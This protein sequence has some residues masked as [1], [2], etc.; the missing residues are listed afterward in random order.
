MEWTRTYEISTWVRW[1]LPIALVVAYLW[2]L[3]ALFGALFDPTAVSERRWGEALQPQ[4]LVFI[5]VGLG[6]VVIL[7]MH[8]QRRTGV[9][10]SD[11]GVLVRTWCCD[12][13]VRWEDIHEFRVG[14]TNWTSWAPIV[15]ERR[16]G[17]S[18]LSFAV[19]LQIFTPASL[20][21]GRDRERIRRVVQRLNSEL[22]QN[23]R[24]G[25]LHG[26]A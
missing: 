20:L 3:T 4:P 23:L 6:I 21:T 12:Y 16:D 9:F 26:I 14:R 11:S 1:T 25:G 8:R 10:V 17:T 19:G 18:V 24:G 2:T 15:L 13:Q 5:L 7:Y 22:Q